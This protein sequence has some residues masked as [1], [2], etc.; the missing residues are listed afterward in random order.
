MYLLYSPK[1][2]GW[3]TKSSTY[4]T[5]VNDAMLFHRDAAILMCKKHKSEAGR[6]MLPVR[7]EDV[8]AV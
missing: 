1:A 5:D 6:N 4:S 2:Q 8:L 3:F 7:Q